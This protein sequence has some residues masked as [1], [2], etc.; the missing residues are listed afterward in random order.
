MGRILL[1]STRVEMVHISSEDFDRGWEMFLK[2]QDKGFS[3]TDC[4]SF[5]VMEE[6]G[7]KEALTFD[8]HFRQ[9]GF[10]VMPLNK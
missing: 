5:L 8:E 9:K 3:F 4:L 6:K 10:G 1:S 7:L 2:Y